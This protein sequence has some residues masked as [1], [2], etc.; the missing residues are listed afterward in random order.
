MAGVWLQPYPQGLEGCT[1]PSDRESR[2][3]R[4]EKG[5][6]HPSPKAPQQKQPLRPPCP[7]PLP[8]PMGTGESEGADTLGQVLPRRSPPSRLPVNLQPAEATERIQTRSPAALAAEG[9]RNRVKFPGASQEENFARCWP[10]AASAEEAL[11]AAAGRWDRPPPPRCP[12]RGEHRPSAPRRTDSQSVPPRAHPPYAPLPS[13]FPRPRT[14]PH[15]LGLRILASDPQP[16]PKSSHPCLTP[17]SP[18]RP[19]TGVAGD[20]KPALPATNSSPPVSG[21]EVLS[22]REEGDAGYGRARRR[23]GAPAQA[24]LRGSPG[25]AAEPPAALT[26]RGGCGRRGQTGRQGAL[27]APERRDGTGG[28]PG[29]SWSFGE[30][31]VARKGTLRA[32]GRLLSLWCDRSSC[33]GRDS[34]F[35]KRGCSKRRG[36]PL[37][38]RSPPPA[39]WPPFPVRAPVLPSVS[40]S[41]PAGAQAVSSVD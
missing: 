4:E 31:S 26:E 23:P 17:R 10:R 11:E 1:L 39:L 7:R 12:R 5:V 38:F 8:Q 9:A 22:G 2:F 30:A 35:L 19:P 34:V 40:K 18:A 16:P 15:L 14:V 36:L 32:G 24:P 37:P 25:W 20:Q 13:V 28:E 33:P 6:A 27:L 3:P 29:T 21:P 41:I